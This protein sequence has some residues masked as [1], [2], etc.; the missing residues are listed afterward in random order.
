[1]RKNK[2]ILLVIIMVFSLSACGKKEKSKPD[3]V[4]QKMIDDI[5]SI[6]DVTIDDEDLIN[7]LLTT[8]STLTDKQKESVNNYNVLLEAQDELDNLL[9][10][11]SENEKKKEEEE[12]AALNEKLKE[13]HMNYAII[14]SKEIRRKLY[15]P[16]SFHLIEV[17]YSDF[18]D[19]SVVYSIHYSGANKLGGTADKNLIALTPN[20]GSETGIGYYDEDSSKYSSYSVAISKIK[21]GAS[22]A[23]EQGWGE[24]VYMDVDF[25]EDHLDD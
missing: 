25:I 18:T 2:Y 14:I 3:A 12:K 6:G 11:K 4:A 19:G 23:K 24:A 17:M 13:K 21:R 20:N 16:D 22:E 1:M 7:K 9:K 10:E 8:Y 15:D 5:N